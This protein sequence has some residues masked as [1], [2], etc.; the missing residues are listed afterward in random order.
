MRQADLL[1]ANGIE[2]ITVEITEIANVGS[3]ISAASTRSP[4]IGAT[5]FQRLFVDGVNLGGAVCR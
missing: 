4:L 2:L 3:L 5:L 1:H